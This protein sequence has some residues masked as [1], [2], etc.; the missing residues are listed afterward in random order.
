M[1]RRGEAP[2]NGAERGVQWCGITSQIGVGSHRDGVGGILQW[3]GQCSVVW[4]RISESR[5]AVTNNFEI[6]ISRVMNNSK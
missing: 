4:G 3:C 1:Q 2:R 5:R 6:V